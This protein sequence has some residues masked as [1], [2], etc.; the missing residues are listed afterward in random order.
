MRFGYD[1]PKHSIAV[2]SLELPLAEGAKFGLWLRTNTVHT[3]RM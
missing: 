2:Y 1:Y 3:K